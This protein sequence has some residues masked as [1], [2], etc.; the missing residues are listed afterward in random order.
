MVMEEI[1]N[2]LVKKRVVE[3]SPPPFQYKHT[4]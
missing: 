4:G 1:P 2:S 3:I